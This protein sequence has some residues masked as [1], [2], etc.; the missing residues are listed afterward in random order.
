MKDLMRSVVETGT[1]YRGAVTG[2][3]VGGK[4]GTSEDYSIQEIK[5]A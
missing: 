3:S 1:A 2:Y 5:S 4:T